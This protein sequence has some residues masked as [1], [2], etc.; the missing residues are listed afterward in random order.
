MDRNTHVIVS[1]P[2]CGQT[3]VP[4]D[5]SRP[6]TVSTTTTWSYR[7]ACGA[8]GRP[9]VEPTSRAGR[10]TR[11]KWASNLE[12]WHYPS[13]LHEVHDGPKMN[14]VD[15]LELHRALLEPDWF[16]AFAKVWQQVLISRAITVRT[17]SR[18]AHRADAAG[19]CHDS[20]RSS[21]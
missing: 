1:C 13:E 12:T 5:R 11:S 7:F 3:R 14:L 6:R 20:A 4:T 16:D 18:P 19:G 15:V 21:S 8:C 9:T 2:E 10:S 17:R